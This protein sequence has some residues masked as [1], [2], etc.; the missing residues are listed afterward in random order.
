MMVS[1][2][3]FLKYSHNVTSHIISSEHSFPTI[4]YGRNT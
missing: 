2:Q 4:P 1:L 3:D